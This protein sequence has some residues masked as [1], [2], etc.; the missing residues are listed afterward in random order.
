[1]AT[2]K[3]RAREEFSVRRVKNKEDR[4]RPSVFMRLKTD[5]S[6]KAVALFRPDPE[7]E[8][9]P[10]YLEYYDHYDKQANQYVP[11]AGAKCPFCAA[12]DNPSTRALTV[13]YYPQ[14][15]DKA[16]KIK[17]FTMNF[18]TIN[19]ITDEDDEVDGILGSWVRVK[20]L[21]DKGDYKVRVTSDKPLTKAELREAMTLLEEK[22][23]DGLDGLV[24]TQLKRQMERL[25]AMEAME[26]DDE[27]EDEAKDEADDEETEDETEDEES[28][29]DDTESDD[30]DEEEESGDEE[31]ASD[32][33][34]EEEEEAEEEEA[35]QGSFEIVSFNESDEIFSLKDDDGKTLRMWVGDKVEVDADDVAKGGTITLE[36]AQDDDGDWII[37]SVEEIKKPRTRRSTAAARKSGSNSRTTRGSSRKSS[38]ARSK[39]R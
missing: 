35:I 23:E 37:T 17:V 26:D 10:G 25:K 38:S 34:D 24:L 1:M 12:N 39:K 29:D 32:E 14:A 20:R 21:S 33:E 9:N 13:W 27:D 7:L 15:S 2:T 18:S 30:D 6:F 3:R 19:D 11:C 4:K 36:A 5:E 16:D 22:F 28:D 8:N 31:E